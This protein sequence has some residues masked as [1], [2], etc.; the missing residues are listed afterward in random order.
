MDTLCL[1]FR[2]M[3]D[4]IFAGVYTEQ[5][6]GVNGCSGLKTKEKILGSAKRKTGRNRQLTGQQFQ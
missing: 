4:R 2:R 1:L 3:I 5:W 6:F